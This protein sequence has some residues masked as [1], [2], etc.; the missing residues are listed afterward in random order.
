MVIC[1]SAMVRA[2]FCAW[3]PSIGQSQSRYFGVCLWETYSDMVSERRQGG[4]VM[5]FVRKVL[6]VVAYVAAWLRFG[7]VFGV[8]AS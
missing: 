4:K 8:D 6:M 2:S 3:L 5:V 7:R 1:A